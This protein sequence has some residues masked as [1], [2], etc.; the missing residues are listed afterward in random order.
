MPIKNSILEQTPNN[1]NIKYWDG[2]SWIPLPNGDSGQRLMSGGNGVI[3]S[4]SDLP[5]GAAA[6]WYAPGSS[7]YIGSRIG[8]A[9]YKTTGYEGTDPEQAAAADWISINPAYNPVPAVSYNTGVFSISGAGVSSANGSYESSGTH[10]GAPVFS[11]PEEPQPQP[12]VSS[13]SSSELILSSSS[14]SSAI[15]PLAIFRGTLASGP[16]YGDYSVAMLDESNAIL[17]YQDGSAPNLYARIYTVSGDTITGSGS[18]IQ[19]EDTLSD[20]CYFP[21]VAKVDSNTAIVVFANTTQSATQAVVLSRSGTTLSKAGSIVNL[22]AYASPYEGPDVAVFDSS[23]AIVVGYGKAVALSISGGNL[24]PGTAISVSC[25]AAVVALD[26]DTAV[27]I[28]AGGFST[29]AQC[30]KRSTLSLTAYG[31]TPFNNAGS[32]GRTPDITKL[33]STKVLVGFDDDNGTDQPAATVLDLTGTTLNAGTTLVI[34]EGGNPNDVSVATLS[35]SLAVLTSYS[36]SQTDVTVLLEISGNTLSIADYITD[37]IEGVNSLD[38][39]DQTRAIFAEGG[40]ALAQNIG[41]IYTNGSSPS[42]SPSP[43]SSSSSEEILPSSSSSNEILSSSSSSDEII[44]SSSSSSAQPL[45]VQEYNQT[46]NGAQ[47]YGLRI[48]MMDSTHGVLLYTAGS[49]LGVV[50]FEISGTT[51]NFGTPAN[52]MNSLEYYASDICSVDSTHAIAAYR[53]GSDGYLEAVCV[54]LSG[55]AVTIQSAGSDFA[56]YAIPSFAPWGVRIEKTNTNQALIWMEGTA[57]NRLHVAS[58][59]GT[60]VTLDAGI[61]GPSGI[62]PDMTPTST[63]SVLVAYETSS[64]FV[65]GRTID[66]SVGGT[67]TVN[68]EYTILNDS[69]LSLYSVAVS[70]MT[71]TLVA[72][73]FMV[74]GLSVIRQA[75][76][77][78]SG[79]TVLSTSSPTLIDSSPT[80]FNIVGLNANYALALITQ[81]GSPPVSRVI[82]M[83]TVD[84][85]SQ[86][87]ESSYDVM[88]GANYVTSDIQ[89]VNDNTAIAMLPGQSTGTEVS[90]FV[91]S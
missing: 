37:P 64:S 58:L 14:S 68:T 15:E 43:S 91:V 82:L 25:S 77:T 62:R 23:Y 1:G 67:I 59:S 27:A 84:G 8:S 29:A 60:T 87:I 4:W 89:K 7:W 70:R 72:A 13:S 10:N 71:D 9:W 28:N 83:S 21:E 17:I 5:L 12:P 47:G 26:S 36:V 81:N 38:G 61:S 50:G 48:C 80:E 86:T 66:V 3:P 74:D 54:T 90:L 69:F 35:E 20:N 18:A 76:I 41:V 53:R 52:L 63:G 57:G 65:K 30:I 45:S 73:I 56:S 2:R 16:Y 55:T 51:V 79:G 42:P 11:Q 34:S 32:R 6:M 85:T 31:T 19:I 39:I 22:M 78:I 46:W 24:S 49:S 40:A 75:M 33:T 88:S 44:L